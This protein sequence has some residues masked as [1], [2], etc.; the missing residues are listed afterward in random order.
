M[1]KQNITSKQEYTTPKIDI[2]TLQQSDILA[3]SG[4]DVSYGVEAKP[5]NLVI[6]GK[7]Y[8]GGYDLM[9]AIFGKENS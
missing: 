3:L 4:V 5:D 9:D 6:Q 1:K 2:E 8:I 7:N